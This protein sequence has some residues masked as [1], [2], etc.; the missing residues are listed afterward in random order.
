VKI[1]TSLMRLALFLGSALALL[2]SAAAGQQPAKVPD[3]CKA[4]PRPEYKSLERV[5][6][7]DPWFEIYKVAPETFAIYEPHQFEETISYLIAGQR[8]AILFDTGMGIGD[9]R[10]V[11]SSLTPL[12]VVVLNSHTHNDHVGDNWQFETVY[13]VDTDFSRRDAAG[14]S[15]D[16]QQEIL[17]GEICGD[18]PP[19]FDG[20]AYRTKPWHITGYLHD[21]QKFDLGGRTIEVLLTPGHTPDGV[22]L[23]DHANGLLFTGDV[24]YPAPIWLYRPETDFNAYNASIKRLAALAPQVKIVLG[25]HNVPVAS[26]SVLPTLVTAFTALMNGKGQCR[27]VSGTQRQCTAGGITFLLSMAP[28]ELH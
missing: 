7:P 3:W 5:P 15:E 13:G 2:P 16:A 18:L 24:Y 12:P 23:F 21:G 26:P 8:Q 27:H 25:A 4:L 17:P 28:L 19:G 1:T 20:A 9:L 14:S 22:T 11:V 6:S 10:R